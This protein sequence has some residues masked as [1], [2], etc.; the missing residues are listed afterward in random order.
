M[1][2]NKFKFKNVDILLS[3]V[4]SIS[5]SSTYEERINSIINN[6]WTPERISM[7][8]ELL[9]N[10]VKG[11]MNYDIQIKDFPEYIKQFK[12]LLEQISSIDNAL[13]IP[14]VC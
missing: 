12:E 5:A 6:K 3:Y 4:L 13:Y 10:D 7:E 14:K 2:Q 9:S 8:H 1:I 11:H